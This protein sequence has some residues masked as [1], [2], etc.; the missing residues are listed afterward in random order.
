[1][2]I[3]QIV[4]VCRVVIT[5]VRFVLKHRHTGRH[6]GGNIVAGGACYEENQEQ[7]K[8]QFTVESQTRNLCTHP[9]L[10]DVPPHM[11]T[12]THTCKEKKHICT[13]M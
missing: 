11:H 6:T 9:S 8:S 1:M 2:R 3:E 7:N 5:D 13:D 10:P 4:L 12:R